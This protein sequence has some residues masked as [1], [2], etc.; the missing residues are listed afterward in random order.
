MSGEL[1]FAALSATGVIALAVTRIFRSI[2]YP[3]GAPPALEPALSPEER[4]WRSTASRLGGIY[5]PRTYGLRVNRSMTIEA[6]AN[7]VDVFV[8]YSPVNDLATTQVTTRL[9]ARTLAPQGFTLEISERGALPFGFFGDPQ[10]L[11][12][13][14][15]W[16]ARFLVRTTDEGLARAW[17]AP[18]VTKTILLAEGYEYGL[19]GGCVTSTFPQFESSSAS[20]ERAVWAV[21]ALASG[22][23]RI[24]E[25]WQRLAK[26][27]G[28]VV[29]EE[30]F[31]A[32]NPTIELD[33]NGAKV[34]VELRRSDSLP[35]VL[36]NRFLTCV[37]T[38]RPPGEVDRFALAPGDELDELDGEIVEL[39]PGGLSDLVLRSSAPSVT[40]SHFDPDLLRGIAEAKP[41]RLVGDETTVAVLWPGIVFDAQRVTAAAGVVGR[42]TRRGT[43][44]PYR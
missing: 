23:A 32:Q 5:T 22:G 33:G 10:L 36:R 11:L 25:G 2:S 27:L 40:A 9:R 29:V 15:H 37:R 43:K 38:D 26:A 4:A 39:D 8:E 3:Q 41:H 17:L 35:S 31:G 30:P 24:R 44:G 20:L 16:D 21:G 28:G 13:D 12:G 14:K 19:K 1:V 34:V 6:R 18:E 42:F 7:G